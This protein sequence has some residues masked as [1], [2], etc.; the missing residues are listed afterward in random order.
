MK[1]DFKSIEAVELGMEI[2]QR[3]K[4][5]SAPVWVNADVLSGPNS[6]IFMVPVDATRFFNYIQQFYEHITISPGWKTGLFYLSLF[7]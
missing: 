6:N 4:L 7:P 3:K 5:N 2:L 1:L